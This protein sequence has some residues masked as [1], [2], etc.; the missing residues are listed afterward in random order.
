LKNYDGTFDGTGLRIAIAVS[1]FNDFITEKLLEGALSALDRHG[2]ENEHT[3]VAHAPGAFELPLVTQR[4]ASSGKFDAVIALGAVIRGETAHFDYVAGQA[5]A[6][7]AS[8]SLATDV[9]IIFGVITTEN[10]EQALHRIGI[11]TNNK[12]FDAAVAAIETATLLRSI[13]EPA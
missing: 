7:I 10:T 2:V 13:S 4:L 9:P 6:G 8:A 11:K 3:V 1:R 12:G 5:A